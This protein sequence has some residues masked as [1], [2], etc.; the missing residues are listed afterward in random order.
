MAGEEKGSKWVE[1]V[2]DGFERLVSEESKMQLHA[3]KKKEVD[4]IRR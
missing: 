4:A 3:I 2:V 1:A